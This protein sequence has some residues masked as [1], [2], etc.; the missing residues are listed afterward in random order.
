MNNGCGHSSRRRSSARTGIALTTLQQI[1]QKAGAV[2]QPS[3]H[4]QG[5][6]ESRSTRQLNRRANAFFLKIAGRRFRAYSALKHIGRTS[7]REYITPLSAYPL[8]DGFVM[9][10]LYGDAATVDWCRNI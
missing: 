2:M 10:L 1:Q 4:S 9:P 6:N 3:I 8:G 5:R 7:G